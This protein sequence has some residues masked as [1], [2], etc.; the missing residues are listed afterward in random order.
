MCLPGSSYECCGR[1]AGMQSL[2]RSRAGAAPRDN[3]ACG[4]R[5]QQQM[6]CDGK[7]RVVAIL[8]D[9]ATPASVFIE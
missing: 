9:L 5:L 3:S 8:R 1:C 7:R 2:F 4:T 6:L